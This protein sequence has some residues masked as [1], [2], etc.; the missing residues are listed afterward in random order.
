MAYQRLHLE[1]EPR[2]A[3][4]IV[5]GRK[6]QTIRTFLGT[7][8]IP[9]PGDHLQALE[10]P[11]FKPLGYFVIDEVLQCEINLGNMNIFLAGYPLPSDELEKF[12][13][14]DGFTCLADMKQWFNQR[15]PD[16]MTY[17]GYLV[18]WQ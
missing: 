11:N 15:Y 13:I 18:S 5:D 4:L 16:L 14:A 12:A 6:R 1:F 10:A 17:E 3:P 8:V 2:F 9:T 7:G